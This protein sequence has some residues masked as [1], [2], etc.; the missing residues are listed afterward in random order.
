MNRIQ[1]FYKNHIL[2]LS[3]IKETIPFQFWKH[4]MALVNKVWKWF[5]LELAQFPVTALE[6]GGGPQSGPLTAF[7]RLAQGLVGTI[8]LDLGALNQGLFSP[9]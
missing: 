8:W 3:A 6:G 4:W 5:S 1:K 9:N 2:L 7:I